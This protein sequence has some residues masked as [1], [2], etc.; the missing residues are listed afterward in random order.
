MFLHVKQYQYGND[1]RDKNHT[2]L[3]TRQI[4]TNCLSGLK[5]KLCK[6]GM[7]TLMMISFS[8]F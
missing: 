1:S 8:V 7:F 4:S 2:S 6:T 3:K 5:A